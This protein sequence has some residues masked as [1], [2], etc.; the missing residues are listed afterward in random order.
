MTIPVWV[1]QQNGKF[2]ASVLGV[3]Q[4]QATGATR[5]AALL[6]VRD[7]VLIRM[8]QGTLV[9]LDIPS[10]QL[11]EPRHPQ[12]SEE[13]LEATREMLAEIYRERDEEKLREFPE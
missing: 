6:A 13:E 10:I 5:D 9:F 8:H 4:L 12:P 3:T 1:E 11:A 2:K 7:L